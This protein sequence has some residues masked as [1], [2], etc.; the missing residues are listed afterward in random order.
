MGNSNFHSSFA[1][2]SISDSCERDNIDAT[3]PPTQ[4][5]GSKID[6]VLANDHCIRHRYPLLDF[7][8]LVGFNRNNGNGE[9]IAIGVSHTLYR[10]GPE[11]VVGGPEESV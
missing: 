5:L 6:K 9:F 7:E 3:I 10:G 4:P 1:S 11:L 2:S 8:L